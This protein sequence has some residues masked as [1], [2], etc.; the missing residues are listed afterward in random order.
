MLEIKPNN[1]DPDKQISKRKI[2]KKMVP[3]HFIL[4]FTRN[5][6]ITKF[7]KLRGFRTPEPPGATNVILL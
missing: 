1:E 3:G 4:D 6:Y 7:S 5:Y 2:Q